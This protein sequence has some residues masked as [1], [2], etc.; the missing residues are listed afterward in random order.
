[1]PGEEAK[2]WRGL[3]SSPGVN[4]GNPRFSGGKSIKKCLSLVFLVKIMENPYLKIGW[5]EKSGSLIISTAR[6][7]PRLEA[8]RR[9]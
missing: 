8:L 2:T 4:W 9:R 1:M 7:P 6:P 3:S 5:S